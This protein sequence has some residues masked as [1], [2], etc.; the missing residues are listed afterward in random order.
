MIYSRT[1]APPWDITF[2]FYFPGL[3]YGHLPCCSSRFFSGCLDLCVQALK[4]IQLNSPNIPAPIPSKNHRASFWGFWHKPGPLGLPRW[5]LGNSH[6]FVYD[7]GHSISV[8][9]LWAVISFTLVSFLSCPDR[10]WA[11]NKP[12][13]Q[14]NDQLMPITVLVGIL[15]L[16]DPSHRALHYKD[17]T[18]RSDGT[19]Y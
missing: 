6:T 7:R 2:T 16:Q 1:H 12:V 4:Q 14:P 3:I 10:C 8:P 15:N 17:Y 11:T 13:V 9:L 18:S 19:W 5:P